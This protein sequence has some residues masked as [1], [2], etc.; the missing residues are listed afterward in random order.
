MP[1]ALQGLAAASLGGC[2]LALPRPVLCVSHIH[3]Y[4]RIVFEQARTMN[5]LPP[6]LETLM[7]CV[8]DLLMIESNWKQHVR[9]ACVIT[10]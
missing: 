5:R 2:T 3:A 6:M 7:N 10:S 4:K 8:C 9:V 1:G